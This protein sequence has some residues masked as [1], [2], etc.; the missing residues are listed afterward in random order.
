MQYIGEADFTVAIG[1]NA[2][3]MKISRIDKQGKCSFINTPDA[4]VPAPLSEKEP[5]LWRE[6]S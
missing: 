6:Q 3:R 1:N 4:T 5:L 2:V